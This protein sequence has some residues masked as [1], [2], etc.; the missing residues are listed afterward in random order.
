MRDKDGVFKN[1]G[2]HTNADVKEESS[3]LPW[4]AITHHRVAP[5]KPQAQIQKPAGAPAFVK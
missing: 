2:N 5:A 3:R 1:V 4:R